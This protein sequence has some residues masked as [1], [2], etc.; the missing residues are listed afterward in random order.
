MLQRL[1]KSGPHVIHINEILFIMSYSI[2]KSVFLII[3]NNELK[4]NL[5]ICVFLVFFKFHIPVECST[6]MLNFVP[7]NLYNKVLSGIRN[8]RLFMQNLHYDLHCFK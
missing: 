1:K 2:F 7:I 6:I 8:K 5:N 3:L 4:I